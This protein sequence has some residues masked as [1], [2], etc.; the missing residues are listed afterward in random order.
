MTNWQWVLAEPVIGAPQCSNFALREFVVPSL[1][2]GEVLVKVLYHTV[3]PGIRARI[4]ADTYAAKIEVGGIIPGMGVGIVQESRSKNFSEGER[5]VGQLAW[6]THAVVSEAEIKRVTNKHLDGLPPHTAIGSMGPSGL[7]AYF[8][9][10]R[11]LQVQKGDS[12]VV[13]SAAGAVG[14]VAGQIAKI[15]GC[16]V[17]GIAGTESKCREL[18]ERYSFDHALNYRDETPLSGEIRSFL[19][20]GVD[21]YFDNVGGAV[22]DAVMDNM[23]DHGRIAVC[24][25]TSEYNQNQPRGWRHTTAIITRRLNV[26][27]FILFDFEKDFDSALDELGGWIRT[28]QLKD[29]PNILIGIDMAAEGFVSQFSANAPGKLLVQTDAG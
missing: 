14:C 15:L 22:T 29:E 2:T 25:Q 13:S 11:I 28:N 23:N 9:M 27:G 17:V 10:K 16:K 21:A 26:Q 4:G 6:A 7:T 3:A 19:P 1:G 18:V 5:V 12:V 24:G 8:G 20:E